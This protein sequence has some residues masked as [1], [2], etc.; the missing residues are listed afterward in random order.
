[1]RKLLI[2]SLSL[3][4]ALSALGDANVREKTQIHFGGFLGGVI[5][6]FGGK[7][8]REGL[9]SKTIVKGNRM[10]R[11]TGS[12]AQLVDL[13]EEKI[14]QLDYDRH[15]YTVKTFAE[16]RKEMEEAQE[17]AKRSQ[18]DEK[19]AKKSDAPEYEVDFEMKNTGNKQTINGFA[20]REVIATVTVRQKGKTLEQGGGAVLTSDM[21]MGPKVAAMQEVGD[22]ERRYFQKLYGGTSIG[23]DMQQMAVLMATSPAFAKAMKTFSEKRSSF[24]GTPIRTTL[25]VD[26]V[27][28][29]NAEQNDQQASDS[30]SSPGAVIGGLMGRLRKRQAERNQAEGE[31]RTRLFES[32]TELLNAST[33]ATSTDVAIPAGFKLRS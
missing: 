33:N 14:Y 8:T 30:S 23:A 32:T 17:R 24:E 12:N 11:T 28:G 25:T 21:W 22:F 6:V 5:N 2:V 10:V 9:E 19:P 15:T 31:N 20:T 7:A 4:V 3:A 1:M 16:L 29:P 18:R 26:T 13:S 27:A